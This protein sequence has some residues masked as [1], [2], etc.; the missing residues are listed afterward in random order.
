[1]HH[2]VIAVHIAVVTVTIVV[3]AAA[4]ALSH[5]TLQLL[6]ASTVER[7]NYVYA[8]IYTATHDRCA[9]VKQPLCDRRGYSVVIGLATTHAQC[10]LLK[11]S[12]SVY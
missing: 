12:S 7:E 11:E 6:V 3:S 9:T 1:V 4:V 8:C 10:R 5:I 2:I